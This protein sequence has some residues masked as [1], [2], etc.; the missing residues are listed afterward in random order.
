MADT[1]TALPATDAERVVCDWLR[2]RVPAATV[3]TDLV[4]Y[5]A[6]DLWL[7]VQR[8]GGAVRY[9]W[10]DEA[11]V[12]V[13]ARAPSRQAAAALAAQARAALQDIAARA[14]PDGAV[15][16]YAAETAGPAWTADPDQAG[17]FRLEWLIKIHPTTEG[18]R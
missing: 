14:A 10:L 15:V 18:G 1:T 6:Q 13:E 8:T 5:R 9:G 4:G 16:S 7:Q 17:R 2:A 11:E 3:A 12:A